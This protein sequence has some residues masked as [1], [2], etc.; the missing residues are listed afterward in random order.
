MIF[1]LPKD[2][3]IFMK[4]WKKELF[5]IPNLLSLFRLGLIPV[6]IRIYLQATQPHHYYAAGGILAIS[7]LTDMVDGKIARYFN[8]ITTVGKVL[9]PAAD[10]FTQLALTV[11]L[12]MHYP[13]LR[14]VLVLFLVKN[15]SSCSPASS[16][17]ARGKA[18]TVP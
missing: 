8:Q 3:S 10:K 5:T 12:S 16:V 6:Y 4:N 1:L 9:D 2:V 7:C 18:W 11:C 13:V 17:S 15:C 14:P